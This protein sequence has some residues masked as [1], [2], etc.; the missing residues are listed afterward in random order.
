MG[1]V[2]QNKD[3]YA[4]LERLERAV[5]N[6]QRQ[7]TLASA[8]ISEG[9]LTVRRGGNIR[10]IDGGSITGE[11]EGNL[12][13][14][15]DAHFGGD[16][17]IDG[18]T[19]LGGNLTFAPGVIPPAAL[20]ARSETVTVSATRTGN[21]GTFAGRVTV[22]PPS[23]AETASVLNLVSLYGEDPEG[24]PRTWDAQ[25][26]ID[27]EASDIFPSFFVRMSTSHASVFQSRTL[28]GSSFQIGVNATTVGGTGSIGWTAHFSSIVIYTN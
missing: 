22:N 25:S 24:D 27:G 18:D 26:W 23:W 7:S 16:L 6:M 21:G 12:D 2:P 3:L 10:V 4:R 9:N 1:A 13:W 20:S 5:N 15:G 28:D 19:T 11:G 8:S 14:E 17:T